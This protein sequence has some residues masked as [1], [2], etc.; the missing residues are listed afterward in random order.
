MLAFHGG[1]NFR[2]H[3]S[4]KVYLSVMCSA[5]NSTEA[6]LKKST[7]TQVFFLLI[8]WHFLFKSSSKSSFIFTFLLVILQFTWP[9]KASS[10]LTWPYLA[11]RWIAV[12]PSYISYQ[13]SQI[14]SE[15]RKPRTNKNKR[16]DKLTAFSSV[17]DA[18]AFKRTST[19]S[20]W[21][22]AAA[23]CSAVELFVYKI[24]HIVS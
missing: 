9:S 20:L 8:L 22:P 4:N 14:M 21:P 3:L 16:K 7:K 17:A 12:I 10:M 5:V 15:T 1:G 18:P 11:H 6:G 2:Q 13:P 24:T 23:R 19:T